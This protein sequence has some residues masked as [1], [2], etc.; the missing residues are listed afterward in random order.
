MAAVASAAKAYADA[1]SA[2]RPLAGVE[3]ELLDTVGKLI[4]KPVTAG[5][6]REPPQAAGDAPPPVPPRD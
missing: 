6:A 4:G 2:Q 3:T 1:A 5:V